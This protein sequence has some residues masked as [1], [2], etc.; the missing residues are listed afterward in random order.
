MGSP[1]WEANGHAA[2]GEDGAT[3]L[4]PADTA[5]SWIR[6]RVPSTGFTADWLEWEWHAVSDGVAEHWSSAAA[7]AAATMAHSTC[8]SRICGTEND[9]GIWMAG[10]PKCPDVSW[11]A[12]LWSMPVTDG[13]ATAVRAAGVRSHV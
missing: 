12:V 10:L 3:E 5:S 7:V 6:I 8:E 9:A 1:E 13:T 2:A 11:S 4:R